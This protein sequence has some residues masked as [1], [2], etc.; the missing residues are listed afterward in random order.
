VFEN[1][2]VRPGCDMMSL[3]DDHSVELSW[4]PGETVWAGERL[5]AADH[6]RSARVIALRG[7]EPDAQRERRV[8]DLDLLGRLAQHSSR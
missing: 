6:D 8:R 1:P 7:D 4:Q 3:V 2:P 5:H